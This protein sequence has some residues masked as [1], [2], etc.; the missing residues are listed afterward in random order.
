MY[1]IEAEP[2]SGKVFAGKIKQISGDEYEWEEWE[3]CT[4]AFFKA[5]IKSMED[6]K[7]SIIKFNNRP[8]YKFVMT[9]L[10]EDEIKELEA[11]ANLD[12]ACLSNSW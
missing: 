5:L 10:T 2:T 7:V 1:Y 8:K 11:K 3:D 4:S 12:G 6:N 9:E